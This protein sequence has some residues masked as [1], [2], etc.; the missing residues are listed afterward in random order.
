VTALV[1]A[2]LAKQRGLSDK[3]PIMVTPMDLVAIQAIFAHRRVFPGV[4]PSFVRVTFEAEFVDR[5][6]PDHLGAK[7]TH[8]IVALGATHLSFP[9]WV[10]RLS[11]RLGPDVLVASEA[12]LGLLLFQ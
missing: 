7:A 3:K 6:R 1:V 4:G 11:V 2:A 12:K 9:D 10:M 5:I 8:G